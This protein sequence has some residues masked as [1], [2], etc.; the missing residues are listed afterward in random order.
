MN[1]QTTPEP[2]GPLRGIRVLEMGQL[3]AGPFCGQ[4]LG[5]LGADVIKLEDPGRGD[6]LRQWGRTR[7]QGQSLWWSIVGRNKRSVTANLRHPDGQRLARDLASRADVVVEN[8]RPGTL[9][10]WGLD[11]GTLSQLN[12]GLVMVRVSGFGQSGPYASRA[13]YGAIGEAMGGLRYVVGD[14]ASPPSRVGISIGDTLAAMFA[15]IGALAALRERDL[16]GRGQVVDSAIYEAVLG[17][18]ESLVPE[19]QIS[20]YQRER[21]GAV[22]PNIAPSNVYPTADGLWMVVAANQDTVFARLAAAMGQPELAQDP[23]FATHAARGERQEELDGLVAD[24]TSTLEADELETLLHDHGVPAGKIYRAAEMLVD[25]HFQARET[26][27]SVPHP[28]LGEVPMQNVFPRLSRTS[29]TIRWPGPELGAHTD[30][31]LAELG[32]APDEVTHLREAG[33]V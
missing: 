5:D 19:W 24:F 16:S 33:V 18:M 22:L 3:L 26:I 32:L 14:P 21:T 17:V 23:R 6:P 28:A 25:P 7:P 29:G 12:P 10:K 27:T 1:D 9:E 31:V 8:F 20:G 11:Y 4:L 13:G 30:E 15:T 2:G